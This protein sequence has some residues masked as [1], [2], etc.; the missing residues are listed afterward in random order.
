M[1]KE[2]VVEQYANVA[3]AVFSDA[4]TT[5]K[6]LD[7]S[8]ESFFAAPSQ[9]SLDQVKQAWI[10]S[11]VPYQ[12]SEVFRFGNSMV[13]DWEGQL[14]AW[15]LDEG[16]IDYVA[17]GYQYELGNEGASANIVATK[18]KIGATN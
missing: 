14:N 10:K 2:Q 17:T 13:D 11:R 15:P 18:L 8:I 1:T 12:Q 6:A 4:L 5:A 9:K 16:L 3:H 7:K